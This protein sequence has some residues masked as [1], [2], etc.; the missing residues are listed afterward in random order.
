MLTEGAGALGAAA[1]LSGKLDVKGKKV[2]IVVF[3]GNIDT[4]EFQE[5]LAKTR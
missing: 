3:G 5:L 4:E 1:L 2:V